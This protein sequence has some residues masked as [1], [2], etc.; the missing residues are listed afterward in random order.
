MTNLS[1]AHSQIQDTWRLLS[2]QWQ[3]TA[4][5]WNDAARLRFEREFIQEYEPTVRTTLKE[6]DKLAQV[7]TQAQKE[8]K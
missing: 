5:Q 8:V 1:Q 2:R 7:I 3:A 6:L 4:A